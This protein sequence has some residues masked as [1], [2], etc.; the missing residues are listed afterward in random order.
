MI[1]CSNVSLCNDIREM[2]LA[3]FSSAGRLGDAV[4]QLAK[5]LRMNEVE[6]SRDRITKALKDAGKDWHAVAAPFD[7]P[8]VK[9]PII[10][11]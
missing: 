8:K 5:M 6:I 7:P 2:E 11:R 3:G 4:P 9:P 1:S 10:P